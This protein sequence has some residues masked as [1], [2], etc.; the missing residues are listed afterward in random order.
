[1]EA[2]VNPPTLTLVPAPAEFWDTVA[3]TFTPVAAAETNHRGNIAELAPSVAV[4]CAVVSEATTEVA[5]GKLALVAPC[6]TVTE[7]W[8]IALALSSLRVTAVPPVGAAA[9]IVT[10]QVVGAGGTTESGAHEIEVTLVTDDWVMVKVLPVVEV[11][12]AMPANEAPPPVETVIA[13]DVSEVE[14]TKVNAT[15]A[16]APFAML[17]ALMPQITHFELPAALLQVMDFPAVAA[18]PLTVTFAETTSW[19]G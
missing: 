17:F 13:A 5:T 3:S 2:V 6:E 18:V 19:V 12:I 8:I 11:G 15:F 9:L 16:T 4:M 10:K 1:V 14:P 7:P